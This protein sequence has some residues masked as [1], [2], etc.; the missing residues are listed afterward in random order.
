MHLYRDLL[1]SHIE[2]N[3]SVLFH[4]ARTKKLLFVVG[5]YKKN[6]FHEKLSRNKGTQ[7][8]LKKFLLHLCS[9]TRETQLDSVVRI[10]VNGIS[11]SGEQEMVSKNLAA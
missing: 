1:K 3:I 7:E 5:F 11:H 4:R 10:L 9:N 2:S 8:N 6:I